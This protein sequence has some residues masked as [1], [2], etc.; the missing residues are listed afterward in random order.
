M[1]RLRRLKIYEP[2]PI[3]Y[4]R[5][6]SGEEW[7][8]NSDVN[9]GET[10]YG[11]FKPEKGWWSSAKIIQTLSDKAIKTALLYHREQ[12]RFLQEELDY[13]KINSGPRIIEH[14]RIRTKNGESYT[15]ID[16]KGLAGLSVQD[17]AVKYALQK[18]RILS[19]GQKSLIFQIYL[20]AVKEYKGDNNA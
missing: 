14:Q 13:R 4:E 6:D 20:D 12:I 7:Q 2:I 18:Q 10:N 16:R 17:R 3:E 19:A 15:R 5:E 9:E 11:D 8:D 1:P